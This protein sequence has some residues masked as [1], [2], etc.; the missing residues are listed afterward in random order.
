MADRGDDLTYFKRHLDRC[1][2]LCTAALTF[3]GEIRKFSKSQHPASGEV[4]VFVP[5][6]SGPTSHTSTT[7]DTSVSTLAINKSS[8]VA[9]MGDR[10]TA[11][12]LK[13]GEGQL[14]PFTWGQLVPI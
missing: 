3:G 5:G 1:S 12:G 13:V 10:A 2:L 6:G 4:S 8:A 11:V 9:E 7:L 14:C